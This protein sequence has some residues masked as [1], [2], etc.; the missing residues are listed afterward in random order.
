M[1]TQTTTG[2]TGS[3]IASWALSGV[4]NDGIDLGFDLTLT[5]LLPNEV[6]SV[7]SDAHMTFNNSFNQ[8]AV[9]QPIEVPTVTA[10]APVSLS[11]A[12]DHTDY[13]AN[14]TAMVTTTLVNLDD[15]RI[16]GTLVVNVYDHSGT[17]VG[18]VTQ[19]SV[20]IPA[21]ATLP[22]TDPSFIGTIL[23]AKYMVK[24]VLS[25]GGQVLAQGETTFNV[26]PDA[27]SASATSTIHT[28]KQ[29]YNSSDHVQILSHVESIA[30]NTVLDNLSLQVNVYSSANVHCSTPIATRSH[31]SCRVRRLISQESRR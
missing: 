20:S 15:V 9:N 30:A 31:S 24:A 16:N 10:T 29:V 27:P 23:P 11:V 7:A 28:D 19:K 18:A 6:R 25:D 14:A 26:L 17:F 13:P 21:D 4:T 5:D 3:L 1:P 8:Q 22:V 12:T 2:A